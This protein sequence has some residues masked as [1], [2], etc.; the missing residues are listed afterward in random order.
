MKAVLE[1]TIPLGDKQF[2]NYQR[3]VKHFILLVGQCI[4]SY[5]ENMEALEK[6]PIQDNGKVKKWIKGYYI[7]EGI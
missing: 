1:F 6:N 3:V 4:R 5:Q 7:D 2:I